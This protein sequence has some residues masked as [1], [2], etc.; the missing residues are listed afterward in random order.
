MRY[1]AFVL[2]FALLVLG[3]KVSAH[4]VPSMV[5]EAEFN[6]EREVTLLV[7]LDPRLFLTDQPTAMPP[8]PASWWFQQ[9]EAEQAETLKKAAAYVDT[10]LQFRIGGSDFR[11]IWKAQPVDSA[12]VAPLTPSSAEV[13]LLVEHKGPL[14]EIAGDF[15]MTVA[16]TCA[17]ATLLMNAMAGAEQRQPQLVFPGESSRGFALPPTGAKA[18]A[19]QGAPSPIAKSVADATP[20]G[21]KN[22]STAGS[23]AGLPTHSLLAHALFAV[24]VTSVLL[25]RSWSAVVVMV[26]FHLASMAAAWLTWQGWLPVA[27]GGL[28]RNSWMM[29]GGTALALL[30]VRRIPPALLGLAVVA[31]F[32]HGWG[33]WNLRVWQGAE[34]PL[35]SL[36]RREGLLLVVGLVAVGL[37]TPCV[38]YLATKTS[39]G[40]F[41][42]AEEG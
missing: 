31:G 27:L 12:T 34:H 9:S 37:A 39:M 18:A 2:C 41:F 36:F 15:K 29:L 19:G 42:S 25:G 20:Q 8:I 1:A 7:N 26:V 13:H 35:S 5:A 6:P 23:L 38:R 21:T 22:G 40:R 4:T 17:V 33:P 16:R 3:Q 32:L 10:Q 24:A 11:G 30:L 14:P 28:P